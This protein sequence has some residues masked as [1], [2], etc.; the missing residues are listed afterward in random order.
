[1]K[2]F[3]LSFE[4]KEKSFEDLSDPISL[5]GFNLRGAV[6]SDSALV[7]ARSCGKKT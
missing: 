3:Y 1:L 6:I 4:D 5:C 2:L 7:S